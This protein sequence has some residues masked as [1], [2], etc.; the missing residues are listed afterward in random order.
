MTRAR[1]VPPASTLLRYGGLALAGAAG[2]AVLAAL[3]ALTVDLVRRRGR[4]DRESPQPG[5][6]NTTVGDSELT[7]YTD[8]RTLYDDMIE[9]IDAA[10]DIVIIENYLWKNDEDGLRFIRAFNAAADRGVDVYVIYDG[11]GNMVVPNSF[12]RNFSDKVRVARLPMVSHKLLTAPVRTT[13]VNHSKILVV[14]DNVGFVG[15]YN[16]GTLFADK[17][18]D[19][20]IRQVGVNN[21]GLRNAVTR[22]WNQKWAR[23]GEIP[24]TAPDAWDTRIR[25]VANLPVQLVYPIRTMH[26]TAIE[27]ACDRIWIT[28]PYFIPDQQILQALYRAADRGVDVRLMVPKESNHMIADWVSRGFYGE[29][30]EHGITL[31]LYTSTMI[32]SKTSTIDGKWSTVGTANIDRLSLS[33]NYETNLEITDD[34]F[35]ALMEEIFEADA[36][37]CETVS[38]ASWRDEHPMA[39]VAEI[40]L[41]PLRKVL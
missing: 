30:L 9:A 21:W 40:A 6:F 8:G 41:R 19:T 18:R 32:H 4:R 5:T 28:S 17:W 15:G 14:D 3:P 16:I 20:H 10:R 36:E 7:V 35:A 24:W 27:R 31:H 34:G 1:T 11:V 37:H 39:K 12:Y 38:S 23:G 25:V 22:V 2:T 29:L 26:L 13:G 33:F